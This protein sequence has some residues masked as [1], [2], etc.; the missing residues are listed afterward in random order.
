MAQ[1]VENGLLDYSAKVCHYWPEFTGNGKENLSLADILRHESG[2]SWLDHS[3]E[4]DDFTLENIKKNKVGEIFE[5]EP[6]HFPGTGGEN[7]TPTNRE[8]HYITRGCIL[9]EIVRRVD[10]K[11]RT[12]GEIIREVQ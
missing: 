6:L 12:M 3:F 1:L 11:G 5:K 10:K 8:Y 2:L 9:N 4:Q 7:E